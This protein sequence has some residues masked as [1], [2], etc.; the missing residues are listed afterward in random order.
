MPAKKTKNKNM[1]TNL[2]D[3]QNEMMARRVEL[4][5][6]QKR[7][8]G[9]AGIQLKSDNLLYCYNPKRGKTC[10]DEKFYVTGAIHG[11]MGI[12]NESEVLALCR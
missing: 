11:M 1:K 4:I 6:L 9:C 8:G 7:K 10:F 2:K 5:A 12:W 3:I